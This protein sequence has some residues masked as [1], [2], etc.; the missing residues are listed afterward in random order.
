VLDRQSDR[1]FGRGRGTLG[2]RM[3][4]RKVEWVIYGF[5]GCSNG[6]LLDLIIEG[7]VWC[8]LV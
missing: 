6:Y 1:L 4:L 5:S 7:G 3:T 2:G 8:V